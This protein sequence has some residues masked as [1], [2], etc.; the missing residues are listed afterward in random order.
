ML[1][2]WLLLVKEQLENRFQ[3]VNFVVIDLAEMRVVE[4]A[5]S[6]GTQASTSST[7]TRA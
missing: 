7:R 1:S 3:W 5:P 2:E 6:G 4:S